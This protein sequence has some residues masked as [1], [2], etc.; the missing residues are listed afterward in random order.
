M[1]AR[2]K[3]TSSCS[4]ECESDLLSSACTGYGKAMQPGNSRSQCVNSVLTDASSSRSGPVA[5][6]EAQHRYLV[7]TNASDLEAYME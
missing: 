3:Y 2:I 5:V 6:S 1:H 4:D 7:L